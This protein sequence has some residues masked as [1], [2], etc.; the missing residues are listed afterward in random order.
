MCLFIQKKLRKSHVHFQIY[1]LTLVVEAKAF[2][3]SFIINLEKE[4]PTA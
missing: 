2:M 3:Q 1:S 4:K